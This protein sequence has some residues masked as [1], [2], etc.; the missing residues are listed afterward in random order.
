MKARFKLFQKETNTMFV[1]I[2]YP[3]NYSARAIVTSG[4]KNCSAQYYY[5]NEI[6]KCSLVKYEP[7]KRSPDISHL[8]RVKRYIHEGYFEPHGHVGL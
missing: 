6:R 4:V 8:T 3:I 5:D 1:T 2:F 7:K